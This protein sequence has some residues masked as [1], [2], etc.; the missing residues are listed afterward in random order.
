M[1]DF[2]QVKSTSRKWGWAR[3]DGGTV[4]EA[5]A[6][7]PTAPARTGTL[8]EM[9][10][11]ATVPDSGAYVEVLFYDGHRVV[12]SPDFASIEKMM[13]AALADSM[14]DTAIFEDIWVR[15]AYDTAPDLADLVDVPML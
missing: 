5:V 11:L 14:M 4:A 13:E 1:I 15:L 9:A 2:A 3:G 12:D 8:A 10:A 7:T 6:N